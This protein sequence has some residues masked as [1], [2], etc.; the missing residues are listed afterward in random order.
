[1]S[2]KETDII[3]DILQEGLDKSELAGLKA[4]LVN[5]DGYQK[6]SHKLLQV[7]VQKDTSIS[8]FDFLELHGLSNKFLH[9]QNKKEEVF[10]ALA[11]LSHRG[12]ESEIIDFLKTKNE[13]FKQHLNYLKESQAAI[14]LVERQELKKKLAK[15]DELNTFDLTENDIKNAVQSSERDRLRHRFKELANKDKGG[16]LGGNIIRFDFRQVLKYAA[17]F[18]IFL[19]GAYLI[20]DNYKVDPQLADNINKVKPTIAPE[21]TVDAKPLNELPDLKPASEIN[22]NIEVI[23]EQNFGFSGSEQPSIKISI[24]DVTTQLNNIRDLSEKE[25]QGK[26]TGSC[27]PRTKHLKHMEDSIVNLQGCY[28]FESTKKQLTIYSDPKLIQ[29][30]KDRLKLFLLKDKY[31]LHIKKDYFFLNEKKEFSKLKKVTDENVLDELI[32]INE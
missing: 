17:I 18:I 29:T 32:L 19:G 30:K 1:M 23:Q 15:L 26:T 25:I 27:G 31:Y 13:E 12:Y 6:F 2:L 16:S 10:E 11:E 9:L 28:R 7:L 20:Y 21:K 5:E 24:I 8:L 4:K 14:K 22:F 3:N